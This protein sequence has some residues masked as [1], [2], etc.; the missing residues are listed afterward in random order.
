[1]EGGRGKSNK[2]INAP[3]NSLKDS[4][5][6]LKVKKMKEKKISVHSLIHNTSGVRNA[7]LNSRMGIR[8]TNKQV[9]Y[10]HKLA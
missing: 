4:N 6:S 7:C 5:A 3:P 1:M 2:S 8:K 10:S 9:N